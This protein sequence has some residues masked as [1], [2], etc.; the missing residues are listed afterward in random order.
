MTE[1]ERRLLL[2]LVQ[3]VLG[4]EPSSPFAED[5]TTQTIRSLA[6]SVETAAEI[7]RLSDALM[8]EE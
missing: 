4:D 8:D 1:D 5:T 7:K 2:L 6:A 3:R